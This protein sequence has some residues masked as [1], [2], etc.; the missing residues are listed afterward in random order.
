M[1]EDGE[2]FMMFGKSFH[3]QELFLFFVFNMLQ[4][5]T[6]LCDRPEQRNA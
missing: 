5:Q 1:E 6:I 2:G 4:P 3:A